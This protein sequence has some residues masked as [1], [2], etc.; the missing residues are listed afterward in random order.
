MGDGRPRSEKPGSARPAAPQRL[1][2][3][4]PHRHNGAGAAA[5]AHRAVQRENA[6]AWQADSS[7]QPNSG[8][9]PFSLPLTMALRACV[10]R[11]IAGAGPRQASV[12]AGAGALACWGVNKQ[13]GTSLDPGPIG[14][15]GCFT[16]MIH[17]EHGNPEVKRFGRTSISRR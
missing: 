2:A 12:L 9:A 1:G 11:V 16:V 14:L 13:A 3:F 7:T 15:T 17:V 4:G 10:Q 8:A 6:V 5:L